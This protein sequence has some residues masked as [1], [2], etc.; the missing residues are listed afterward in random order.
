MTLVNL[1][2]Q[3][4]SGAKDNMQTQRSHTQTVFKQDGRWSLS[5]KPFFVI[6]SELYLY[7][8]ANT[9]LKPEVEMPR[10]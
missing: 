4:K 7:A 6:K 8:L 3:E 1:G 10:L 5:L 2:I 9:G